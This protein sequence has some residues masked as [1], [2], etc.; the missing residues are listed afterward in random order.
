ME[1]IFLCKPRLLESTAYN[2]NNSTEHQK[3]TTKNDG[4]NPQVAV[5]IRSGFIKSLHF[6]QNKRGKKK[7]TVKK[8]SYFRKNQTIKKNNNNNKKQ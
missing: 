7:Q 4:F 3:T 5:A 2:N 1:L 6:T 8:P